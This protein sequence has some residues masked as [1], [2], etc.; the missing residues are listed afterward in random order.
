MPVS[1]MPMRAPPWLMIA[2]VTERHVTRDQA[3]SE[4]HHHSGFDAG[5]AADMAISAIW[6]APYSCSAGCVGTERRSSST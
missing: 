2:V 5:A 1:V 6:T 4:A 3:R